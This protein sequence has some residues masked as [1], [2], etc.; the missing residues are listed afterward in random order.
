MM[1]RGKSPLRTGCEKTPR[2]CPGFTGCLRRSA[3]PRFLPIASLLLLGQERVKL[4]APVPKV[5]IL[6]AFVV[7]VDPLT[8][9]AYLL[10]H[11]GI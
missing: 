5:V 9:K 4:D 11:G 3:K 10:W 2:A 1:I 7:F 6:S 8:R